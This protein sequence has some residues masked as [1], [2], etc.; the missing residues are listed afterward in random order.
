MANAKSSPPSAAQWWNP[1]RPIV[2]R[3][4]KLPLGIREITVFIPIAVTATLAGMYLFPDLEAVMSK[5]SVA[6]YGSRK[7]IPLTSYHLEPIYD[8]N[9]KLK[10]YREVKHKPK[11]QDK[12][13]A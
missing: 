4:S 3:I 7:T 8:E 1:F 9:G 13:T 12:E 6:L 11:P 10:A 2:Q 5:G